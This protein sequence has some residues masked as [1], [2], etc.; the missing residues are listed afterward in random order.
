[1]NGGWD[2]MGVGESERAGG[3]NVVGFLGWPA[4]NNTFNGRVRD[5]HWQE[6]RGQKKLRGDVLGLVKPSPAVLPVCTSCGRR[7]SY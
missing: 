3:S 6:G 4:G 1:M 5:H 7:V 2:G